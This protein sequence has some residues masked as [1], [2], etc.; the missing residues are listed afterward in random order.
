MESIFR[1]SNNDFHVDD[2]SSSSPHCVFVSLV[3]FLLLW[4]NVTSCEQL[5]WRVSQKALQ[6][7]DESVHIAFAGRLVDNVFV[8]V[9]PQPSTQFFVVHFGFIFPYSPASCH[10]VGVRQ[11]E[12]PAVTRPRDEMLTGFVR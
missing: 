4:R 8:V 10:L 2:D 9:V 12:F 3:V 6:I 5:L 7:T 11:F 1:G